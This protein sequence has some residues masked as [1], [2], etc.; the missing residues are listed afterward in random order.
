MLNMGGPQTQEDVEPFLTNLFQD[1]DIIPLGP[2]QQPLGKFIAHRRTP[3]VA[4]QYEQIGGG[5][6]IFR[7]T[8]QQGELMCKMLDERRPESAPHKHYVA[9]RYA[10][11]LA[12]EALEQAKND[13]VKRAIAFSQYMQ[14]SCTTS[15]SSFNFLW[16]EADRLGLGSGS[17]IEWSVIDR[18]HNHPK[19]I[20]AVVDRIVHALDRLPLDEAERARVPILFS[21]HGIPVKT[22][23]KGDA[24]PHEIASTVHLVM[25][26]FVEKTSGENPHVL[27]WQSKVGPLPWLRPSTSET[28]EKLG[29]NGTNAVCV[30]PI[31]FTTDHIETL[32]EID[33]EYREEAEKVGIK[34]FVR[35]ESLNDHPLL[36]EALVDLVAK[37]L[38]SGEKHGPQYAFHCLGCANPERCRNMP[39]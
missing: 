14:W 19:F 20:D 33:H 5:S 18:W 27:C 30:V 15:G 13:G 24:Y 21:A 2:F 1:P 31:A 6:P 39:E 26:R 4:K 7:L 32:F 16:S 38:D 28:L 17:G 9:F 10:R 29:K 34:H 25:N 22:M 23:S 37:H 3:K 8:D 35:S 12:T 36:I 11:P